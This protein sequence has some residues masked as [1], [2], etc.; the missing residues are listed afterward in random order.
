[1]T[2][3]P[4]ERPVSAAYIPGVVDRVARPEVAATL[5][6]RCRI[7][8]AD[9]AFAL[10]RRYLSRRSSTVIRS[11]QIRMT[12]ARGGSVVAGSGD[13]RANNARRASTAMKS[14][15]LRSMVN[16]PQSRTSL[17]AYGLML[18]MSDASISPLMVITVSS[19]SS[20][21]QIQGLPR[22]TRAPL[23][24]GAWATSLCPVFM[25]KPSPVLPRV[26]EWPN[27]QRDL[28]TQT[29]KEA[30][31]KRLSRQPLGFNLR[32]TCSVH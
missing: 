20:R 31:R 10:T 11:E 7:R 23:R 18:S 28:E 19:A 4:L 29:P 17:W 6:P 32:P 1:M 9:I 22:S 26:A 24:R 25:S 5:W 15:P 14:M 12:C 30:R 2:E 8:P 13:Q 27:M 21:I 3:S 16:T